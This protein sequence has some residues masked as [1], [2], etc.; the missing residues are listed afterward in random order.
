MQI[1]LVYLARWVYFALF[2]G[3]MSLLIALLH[4]LVRVS[5]FYNVRL[6]GIFPLAPPHVWF[7][8]L[9]RC[10]A[11][12]LLFSFA[13][14]CFPSIFLHFT[15]YVVVWPRKCV[16]CICDFFEVIISVFPMGLVSCVFALLYRSVLG[17]GLCHVCV[18]SRNIT[19]SSVCS[20]R[21][22]VWSLVP[23]PSSTNGSRSLRLSAS[24]LVVST[25]MIC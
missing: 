1:A 22:A 7:S 18:G 21:F 11:A 17:S 2:V 16:Y 12:I 24:R 25:P 20:W 9:S 5:F 15:L 3:S 19:V 23:P 13:I 14:I 10:L 4:S 6:W 8:W